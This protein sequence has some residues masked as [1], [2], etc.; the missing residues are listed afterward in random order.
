[1]TSSKM[2]RNDGMYTIVSLAMQHYFLASF[3]VK[4]T[5]KNHETMCESLTCYF[6]LCLSEPSIR[7]SDCFVHD[8]PSCGGN[9]EQSYPIVEHLRL[10]LSA[11]LVGV[12]YLE[13]QLTSIP[14][15]ILGPP[16]SP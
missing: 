15:L 9:L 10:S 16:K 6:S 7:S 8:T 13:T 2:T 3:K 11:C 14:S 12:H 5:T 4:V 1:M